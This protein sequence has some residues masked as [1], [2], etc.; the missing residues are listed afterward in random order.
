MENMS[1]DK[2]K[3]LIELS[4]KQGYTYTSELIEKIYN[5]YLVEENEETKD[6]LIELLDYVYNY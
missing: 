4:N 3:K 2:I 6:L 1:E 5:A